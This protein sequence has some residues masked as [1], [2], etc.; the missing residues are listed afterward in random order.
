MTDSV[1][2]APERSAPL[3]LISLLQLQHRARQAASV[4]ALGFV[5]VNETLQLASYRQAALWTS[6]GLGQVAAVS[7]P[8]LPDPQAPYVQWLSQLFRHLMREQVSSGEVSISMLPDKVRSDWA[9]WLPAHALW[10]PLPARE[11]SHIAGLLLA[12]ETPWTTNEI[13]L[14][15]ELAHAYG[16]ALDA[17]QPR[18]PW[19]EGVSALL[20]S[21]K[22]RRWLL[23]GITAVVFFPVRLTVLSQAEVVPLDPFVVRAPMEGVI[24][25]FDVKPN[26]AVGLGTPLFS[27]DTTA[28]RARLEVARKAVDTARE[29][30]R[31]SAQAAVTNDKTRA[32]LVLRQGKVQEKTVEL[33][34]TV[35]QL[36]RVQVKAER[37]GLAI[38]A[39]A[40]DWVGKAVAQGERVLM[41]ANPSQV[42]LVAWLP[43]ADLLPV[44][45]GDK[46]HLYPQGSPLDSFEATVQSIAYRAELTREGYLAYRV[47][48]RFDE[49]SVP[50]RI[51]QLGTARMYGGWVPLVYAVLRRPLA[52]ARQWLGW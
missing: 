34:Y 45:A 36:D 29:E 17:L 40:N 2:G 12:R 28:L 7:G 1:M 13:G 23:A 14:L 8:P 6:T 48:A 50:P 47:K 42:E 31:Q 51:G 19:Q 9:E 43:A 44:S 10:L 4:Q 26:Q 33:D 39:D 41:V 37:S 38:F 22:T 24:D 18:Q 16:H 27:L 20:H 49:S 21:A 25:R 52:I 46:L 11:K 35:E 15:N 5:A 3:P 32:D 30:Y